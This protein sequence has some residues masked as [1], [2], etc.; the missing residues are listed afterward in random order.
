M[1]QSEK[2]TAMAIDCSAMARRSLVLLVL[3]A[4]SLSSTAAGKAARHLPQS[5]MHW[6]PYHV[7]DF[8]LARGERRAAGRVR[9]TVRLGSFEEC[10]GP[11]FMGLDAVGLHALGI[12]AAAQDEAKTRQRELR[13]HGPGGLVPVAA[14][15]TLRDRLEGALWGLMIGDAMAMPAHWYYNV[16]ALR[17]DYGWIQVRP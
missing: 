12:S 15:S 1:E 17:R 11:R 16:G 5:P 9:N 7:A 14:A 4:V 8:L 10:D 6:S 3:G 13:S 2:S